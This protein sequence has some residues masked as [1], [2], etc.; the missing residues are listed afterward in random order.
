MPTVLVLQDS[1]SSAQNGGN[2]VFSTTTAG[3]STLTDRL[4]IDS[5][6]V[7]TF[8]SS[9]TL[10][11][12]AST[13]TA[14]GSTILG[15]NAAQTLT[16]N[17][18]TAF[19]STAA[20]S[21]GSTL[22][23]TG[24]LTAYGN[25]S[26]GSNSTNSLTVNASAMFNAAATVVGTFTAGGNAVIGT[27]SNTVVVNSASIFNALATFPAGVALTSPV[28]V[29]GVALKT[30]AT[31]AKY[32]DLTGEPLFYFGS[33]S[34]STAATG[35]PVS[36]SSIGYWYGTVAVSGTSGVATAYPT[37]TGTSSGTA[38]FTSILSVS[39]TAYLPSVSP[40]SSNAINNVYV[41][42]TTVGLQ[43]V[44]LFVTTFDSPALGR[45]EAISAASGTLAMCTIVG[46]YA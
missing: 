29:N 19:A 21:M 45:F 5:S 41:S 44:A 13:L 8:A 36:Q 40:S 16:V 31:S 43:S 30:V 20:V 35:A 42:V 17:A 1:G 27:S 9:V 10:S 23:V 28:T 15:T 2:L 22:A 37:T 39:C 14:F 3:T 11:S 32:S 46:K 24:Q 25:V 4:T 7:A 6:G 12:T 38:L 33:S 26:L 34:Y 18:V